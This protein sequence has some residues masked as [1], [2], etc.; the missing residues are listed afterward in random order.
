MDAQ[1]SIIGGNGWAVDS[2]QWSWTS[3]VIKG[4]GVFKSMDVV[5]VVHIVLV[6]SFVFS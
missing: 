2:V 3:L 4:G 1:T 6:K 5:K